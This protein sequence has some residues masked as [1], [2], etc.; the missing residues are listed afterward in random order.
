VSIGVSY[1]RRN[2]VAWITLDRP[3]VHNALSRAVRAEIP[4]ALTRAARDEEVEVVVIT[5]RGERAFSA[6]A[7]I[8]EFNGP[9][10]PSADETRG[11]D[12]R[13]HEAPSN[14]P[15]PVIAAINGLCLGGGLELA[16]ACDLRVCARRATFALPE[17]GVG[18]IPGGGGTQ[19][20]ARVVGLGPALAMILTAERIDAEEAHRIGLVWRVLDDDALAGEAQALALRIAAHGALALET[21]KAAVYRGLDVSL[22]A[23]L[24]LEAELSARIVGG[25]EQRQR[26]DAFTARRAPRTDAA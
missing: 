26:A 8:S 10:A 17:V 1:E 22:D 18:V 4:R 6:G 19:R 3:E 16:L 14:C 23:G 11:A 7:D 21:A 24:A 2:S 5:G 9:L 13:W 12:I 25:A 15:K 20:L